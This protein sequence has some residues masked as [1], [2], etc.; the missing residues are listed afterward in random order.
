MFLPIFRPVVTLVLIVICLAMT[1]FTPGQVVAH[2]ERP[3]RM[4]DGSGSVPPY[5]TAN[6][7]LLVCKADK[8]DFE[9]RIAAFP[10]DLQARNRALWDD[11]QRNGYRH[12]Q[13]AVNQVTKPG[14]TIA[15]L[16]GLYME[17]P[18]QRLPSPFCAHMPVLPDGHQILTFEQQVQCPNLQNLVAILSK[19]NLQ[20]EGTGASPTD[21]IFDAAYNKLNAIRA[22]RA[23]GIYFR[24][25][26]AQ[27]TTFNAIYVM[28]SDGFVLDDVVG[29]W[30]DA[31]GFLTFA[32]DHGLYTDCEAYGNGDSGVYPGAASNI[33][34][35]RGFDVPRYAIEI[36]GCYSHDNTLGYSGTAGD[37][38]WAHD[39]RFTHNSVGVSTDSAFPNH[40][41]MPQNHAKF[42]RN[43]I[44]D[45]NVDYYGY[46]RDGTCAK[47]SVQRNYE[48]GVVCPTVG[49]PVG[50]GVFNPGGNYNIWSD[51]WVYGN[52]YAGFLLSW[53]PGFIRRDN[54]W[55]AQFD[56]SHHNRFLGN[57]LGLKPAGEASPN[58]LDFW[59]DGQGVD[60]CWQ[61]ST[62]APTEPSA[63]PGCGA[64]GNPAGM[65]TARLV[66]EP[67]K[68]LKLITCFDYNLLRAEI[69]SNCAWFGAQGIERAEV[70]AAVG[71]YGLIAV[72]ALGLL[73]R[74][75]KGKQPGVKRALVGTLIGIAGAVVS[76]LGVANEGTP[77]AAIGSALL[78]LYWL[79]TGV[80]LR[81]QGARKLGWLTIILG[82][83]ALLVAVDSGLWMLP[84]TPISPAWVLLL[85]EIVW[86]PWALVAA[87][88]RAREQQV[89]L[90][91]LPAGATGA[92]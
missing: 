15:V 46:V 39:N 68:S 20:I 7:D 27:H 10:A 5:R 89:M 37:S 29:R 3:P 48:G 21:V 12:L 52:R 88:R 51:N 40:P 11:C 25:L 75:E 22:D 18:S 8:A 42:E 91:T 28:E 2:I 57:K 41:G 47:P 72:L 83:V 73:W 4:P 1:V 67:L 77:L 74:R 33:N 85:L 55:A 50:T 56:T 19:T 80:T 36:K 82:V 66:A 92:T 62:S 17:E 43:D 24:N 76:V 32:D 49:V 61:A 63:L 13:E 64:D 14:I 45:N 79:D 9:R 35:D 30:T 71:V 44:G 59:W 90:P 87:L 69:P 38:V 84:W 16:P 58:G 86:L 70:Q 53:V 34:A 31:Y 6:P 23:N 81:A 78:G 54:H 60:N 26:T 65:G